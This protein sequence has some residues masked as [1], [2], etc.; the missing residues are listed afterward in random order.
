M[1]KNH[2]VCEGGMKNQSVSGSGIGANT[3]CQL[4]LKIGLQPTLGPSD[5]LTIGVEPAGLA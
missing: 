3:L 2:G 4:M 1:A 5:L